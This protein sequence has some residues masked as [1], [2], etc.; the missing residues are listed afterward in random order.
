[1]WIRVGGSCGRCD[2]MAPNDYFILKSGW[3]SWGYHPVGGFRTSIEIQTQIGDSISNCVIRTW[4]EL[5]PE[6]YSFDKI[7]EEQ[8]FYVPDTKAKESLLDN[9]HLVTETLA[10]IYALQGNTG[11]AIRAYQILS[12]KFP[13]KSVYFASLIK[14]LKNNE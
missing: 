12:L 8:K 6:G 11:K 2:R 1:M 14:K 13:Q 7:K 9:E 4:G 3:A 10:K 5:Y